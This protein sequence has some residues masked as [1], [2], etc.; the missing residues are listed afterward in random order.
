MGARPLFVDDEPA[1]LQAAG[2]IGDPESLLADASM[3]DA[4]LLDA[5]SQ[6]VT[7]VGG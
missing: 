4:P 6:T 2:A 7:G 1:A 5:Y 3:L